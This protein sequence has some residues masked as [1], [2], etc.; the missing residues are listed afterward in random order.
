MKAYFI[1]GISGFLGRNLTIELLKQKDV[2]I[3][4]L[5]LPNEKNLE[6]YEQYDNI[7]LLRGN[8]LNKDEV[9][10]F[11]STPADGEKY[12]IHAAGKISV[13]KKNDPLT[14]E[15]NVVG[16]RNVI[17]A[18]I[19]KGFKKVVYVSSVDS[20]PKRKGNDVIYE[21]EEYDINKVD[22]VYSKSKVQANDIVLDA[23]KNSGL[24][25]CIV[26]PSAIMG[27]NDPFNAPINS[28][29][30]RFLNNKLPAITKGGYDIVDVRDVAKGIISVLENGIPGESYLLTGHYITVKGL[31]E[32]AA[33]VANKKPVRNKVPHFVIKAASPFIQAH[34]KAHHKAPLFTGFSMDCLMQNS[35]YSCEKAKKELGYEPRSLEETMKDTINWMQSNK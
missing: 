27:P 19:N 3:V 34:A 30:K 31:I 8:I 15:I 6:F 22:G 2:Q 26:L 17:N 24:D 4:G 13:Y 9:L 10:Q 7:T 32:N 25:A 1:T 5:V 18:C 23:V 11:L 28:A 20:V 16:T 35:N 21:P 12:L 29:I 33:K 14:T